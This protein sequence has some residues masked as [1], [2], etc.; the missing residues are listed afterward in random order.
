MVPPKLSFEKYVP[1]NPR[2]AGSVAV[3]VNVGVSVGVGVGVRVGPTEVAVGVGVGVGTGVAV[4]VAVGVGVGV[5]KIND[6][7]T[8]VQP[9]FNVSLDVLRYSDVWLRYNSPALP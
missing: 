7:V 4:G 1:Y 9:T 6:P 3:G 2:N 5:V 8:Y